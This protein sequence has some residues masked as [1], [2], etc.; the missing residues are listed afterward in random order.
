MPESTSYRVRVLVR[1]AA[2][3]P[4][5]NAVVEAV[6]LS[7]PVIPTATTDAEGA[8]LLDV[9]EAT[10]VFSILALK[11]G[12]GF[13]YFENYNSFPPT[14][15]LLRLPPD[16]HL[17][18]GGAM[19]IRVQAVDSAGGPRPGVA[20]TPWTIQ[21][22]GKL[23]YANC[24]G[25][26]ATTVQ[27]DG[28]GVASFDWI[29]AD[30]ANNAT[31][32]VR[33]HQYHCPFAPWIDLA[34]AD[35][36]LTARL[37]RVTQM[38]GRVLLPDGR[39]AEGIAVRAEGKGRTNFYARQEVKSGSDGGYEFLLWPEQSY[40]IAVADDAW[41]ARSLTGVVIHEDQVQTGLDLH[42]TKGTKVHGRVTVG[43]ARLPDAGQTVTVVEQGGVLS[44]AL[45]GHFQQEALVRWAATDSEGRYEIRLGPG[46]YELRGPAPARRS[47]SRWRRKKRSSATSIYPGLLAACSPERFDVRRGRVNSSP[48]RAS[49]GRASRGAMPA[50]KPPPTARAA[51]RPSAGGN[52]RWCTP[53][54][55]RAPRRA[56]VRLGRK[57]NQRRWPFH[58]P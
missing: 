56:A 25:G 12:V 40:I 46:R 17:L 45:R 33:D 16:A 18:L 30:L 58:P 54:T 47:N 28:A 34:N 27:T 1:D 37:L 11:A 26:R 42:L 7:P 53:A 21:R 32:L 29:P 44:D 35:R 41:A 52:G 38:S 2:G 50:L 51:F 5:P 31:L 13:D 48:M 49:V 24:S 6:Q 8:A 39:P 23:S 3:E 22:P 36:L 20:L 55:R 4:V 10:Q 19:D 57:T 43:S 9:P 15:P 14:R